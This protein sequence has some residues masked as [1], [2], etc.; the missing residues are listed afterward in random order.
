[1]HIIESYK[2][3]CYKWNSSG[4]EMCHYICVPIT[5]LIF[6]NQKNPQTHL[7]FWN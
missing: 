6:K 7:I 2:Y 3:E 5:L 4:I 1:M